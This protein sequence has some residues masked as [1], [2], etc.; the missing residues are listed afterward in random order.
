MK[1]LIAL[2]IFSSFTLA[3]GEE[4]KSKLSPVAQA[5]I[6]QVEKSV[7]INRRAYD[8]ANDKAFDAAE[9]VLKTEQD[10]LTK[11][12]KLEEAVEVKRV[13]EG[14]RAAVVAKVDEA[15]RNGTGLL[16]EPESI[17]IKL[18]EY[19]LEGKFVDCTKFI[20]DKTNNGRG[21][22][23][24]DDSINKVVEDPVPYVHKVIKITYILN[25]ISKTVTFNSGTII[26]F[27]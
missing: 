3:N 9:K 10:K 13:L 23:T 20:K 17:D 5:A 6:A 26:K 2:V 16:G 15:A 22:W 27:K 14:L 25:G 7:S 18:A 19:G 4:A 21:E 24:F 11:T 1:L 12:G 8:V